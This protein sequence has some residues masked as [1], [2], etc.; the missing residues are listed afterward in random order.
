MQ[1]LYKKITTNPAAV[2]VYVSKSIDRWERE[3]LK[4]EP[5]R[6]RNKVEAG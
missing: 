4:P 6:Q 3:N 5:S 2:K 1:K